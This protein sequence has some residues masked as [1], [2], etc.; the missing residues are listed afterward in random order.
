MNWNPILRL[1]N[2]LDELGSE[3]HLHN[4]HVVSWTG[5]A[6][7]VGDYPFDVV[8]RM[9]H[10]HSSSG[11]RIH[12]SVYNLLRLESRSITLHEQATEYNQA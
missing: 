10:L 6:L 4:F 2:L 1:R 3:L 8:G 7:W 11:I 9:H 5:K 12:L